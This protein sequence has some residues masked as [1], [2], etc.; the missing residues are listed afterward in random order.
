VGL[1]LRIDHE[2]PVEQ[3]LHVEESSMLQRRAASM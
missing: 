2:L 1:L 3:V